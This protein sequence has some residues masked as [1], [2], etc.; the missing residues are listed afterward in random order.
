[1]KM[2]YTL[3]AFA[4][5]TIGTHAAITLT[6][7]SSTFDY[8]Y[9]MD[10]NP[11]AQNLD[12]LGAE[13]WFN[14]TSGG[15]T[16]PPVS[17]GFANSNQGTSEILLRGDFNA[18]GAG[19]VWRE[20]VSGGAA[21]D[22][23]LEVSVAKVSGTQGS[24]GWFGIATANLG[25]SNSS[26]LTI[27]DDRIR[28]TGGSDYLVGS[29]FTTGFQTIRVAHDAADN[30]YYYWVNGTLLNTDL[31]TAIAGTNGNGFVNNTFIGD[32][33]GSLAGEWQIDYVRIDTDAIAAVPEPSSAALLGLG[34]LA[35]ILRRR[36]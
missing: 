28:L 10:T 4:V 23:T 16:K 24:A 19:S 30:S 33:S 20:L 8:K 6:G 35:L 2:K 34:G 7:D 17:G 12:A 36:K 9:E 14:G 27:M 13:D 11:G 5:S 1:M 32:Y 25:E 31:S 15:F 26:A 21:S 18:G 29:D 22:W 3:A